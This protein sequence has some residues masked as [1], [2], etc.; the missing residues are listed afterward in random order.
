M[1]K[2]ESIVLLMIETIDKIRD[3]TNGLKNA[4]EFEKDVK[5]FDATIMNF[6]ILGE[7]TGK[8]SEQFKELHSNIDW[9]KIYAFRN[10]LAHDYFG[11]YP[12]EVWEI[13]QKNLPMLMTD[14]KSI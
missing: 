13:I 5:T 8:L 1:H 9:R 3:F 2:D 12:A 4:E 11:I 10:V 14:L 7:A 6:I